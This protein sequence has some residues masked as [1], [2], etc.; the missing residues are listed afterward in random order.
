MF[1]PQTNLAIDWDKILDQLYSL[2]DAYLIG[3]RSFLRISQKSKETEDYV[4]EGITKYLEEPH[5]YD[6][7]QQPIHTYLFY[8]IIRGI[9][10]NDSR[11]LANKVATEP[12]YGSPELDYLEPVFYGVEQKMDM[13]YFLNEIELRAQTN[14]FVKRVLDGQRI[15]M[16]RREICEHYGISETEY[17][18][19]N[20]RLST[21]ILA[22]GKKQ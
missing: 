17:D 6:R 13:D 5:K 11:L 15:G 9:I 3:K 22:V 19:A 16:K 21:I 4:F 10:D 14:I 8:H 1:W 12:L 2:T 18:R 20:A 7:T